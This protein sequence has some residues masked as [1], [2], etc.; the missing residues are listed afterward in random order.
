LGEHGKHHHTVP[1]VAYSAVLKV[2]RSVEVELVGDTITENGICGSISQWCKR[3]N[4]K[5]NI[6]HFAIRLSD[7]CLVKEFEV[8][9]TFNNPCGL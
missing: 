4:R 8:Q 6:L 1:N 9:L 3:Y 5:N 7:G 2:Y